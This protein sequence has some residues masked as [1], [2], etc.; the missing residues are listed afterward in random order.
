MV[1]ILGFSGRVLAE[2][3][4]IENQAINKTP[5]S[6][7]QD[8]NAYANSFY[9]YSWVKLNFQD[10]LWRE[11]T[12]RIAKMEGNLASPYADITAYERGWIKN[13]SYDLGSYFKSAG[14]T[15]D[16]GAG[17]GSDITY[18]Y[19][20]KIFMDYERKLVDS[21]NWGFSGSFFDY[22]PGKVGI[23]SP[24][25]IYYFGNNYLSANAGV[26]FTQRRGAAGFGT[27]KAGLAVGD[28]VNWWFGAA[29]GQRLYDAA[30]LKSSQQSGYILFNGWDIKLSKDLTF[31]FG[32]SYSFEH[33][34]FLKRSLESGF[35]L[36]F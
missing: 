32:G 29:L 31:R 24:G 35:A 33:P 21:L 19:R 3:L 17:F 11:W 1:F 27:I 7:Q 36:K 25:L 4:E 23:I 12:T 28:K 6:I 8:R 16:L 34:H 5:V 20:Y 10:I 14:G 22:V 15:L 30:V 13:Y 9:E 2:N 18:I 26:S